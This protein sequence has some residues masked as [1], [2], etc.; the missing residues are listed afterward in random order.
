MVWI[1]MYADIRCKTEKFNLLKIGS[2]DHNFLH[3]M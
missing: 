2:T 1:V 3:E